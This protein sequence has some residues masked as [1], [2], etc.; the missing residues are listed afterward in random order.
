MWGEPEAS[1]ANRRKLTFVRLPCASSHPS[2]PF[3]R[4]TKPH[5]ELAT[6]I[7]GWESKRPLTLPSLA[8]MEW[9]TIEERP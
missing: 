1:H 7:D 3:R 5:E 4:L 9:K 6:Y 8:R 2:S